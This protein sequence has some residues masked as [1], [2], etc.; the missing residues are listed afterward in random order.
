MEILPAIDTRLST[1]VL[2]AM[3]E[4]AQP[5][6]RFQLENFVI[7]Q[8]TTDEMRYFQCVTEIQNLYFTIKQVNLDIKIKQLE[9]EEL[10][11]TQN[12]IDE[13][14]AQK[15]EV[16]LE[17]VKIVGVGTF[18]E[19]SCLLDIFESFPK[20][21]SRDE[22]DA[23]QSDY[24]KERLT[25]QATLEHIGNDGKVNW[26]SLDALRQIGLIEKDMLNNPEL[27]KEPEKAEIE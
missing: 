4:I 21:Y 14:K 25:R 9:I 13:L 7:N 6:S 23:G 15:M 1:V 19:L 20:K 22:I 8:H 11:K 5:R 12:P 27:T 18:R 10:R 17:A 24:W 26:A 16:D 2:D 3:S